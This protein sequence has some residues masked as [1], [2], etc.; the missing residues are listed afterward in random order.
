MLEKVRKPGRA[1]NILA[2]IIFGAICLTFVFISGIP[3][4]G[5]LTSGGPVALV[6]KEPI[7][8]TDYREALSRMQEQYKSQLDKLPA[9]MRQQ[10]LNQLRNN[11]LEML[12]NAQLISQAAKGLGIY[13][14]DE[15]VRDFIVDIPAFQ[16][17]EKFRRERY[18]NYLNYRRI[19]AE[20]FEEEIRKDV[21]NTQVRNLLEMSL[22][23]SKISE[24]INN[25]LEKY[26]LKVD[27]LRFP[28][29]RI[30][31]NIKVTSDEA[32][33]YTENSEHEEKLKQY[34]E[35]NKDKYQEEEQVRARH[36]LIKFDESKAGDKESAFKKIEDIKKRLETEDFEKLAGEMSEDPGSKTKGGDLGFFGRGKMVPEFEKV[37]FSA[38]LNKV[39]EPVKSQFGYHLIKVE[40]KKE[41]IKKTLEDVK[42][43]VAKELIKEDKFSSK[44]D[45]LNDWLKEGNDKS[46][47][48][49][50][51]GYNLNWQESGEFKLNARYLPSL[52]SLTE[53]NV[54]KVILSAK[55]K[56]DYVPEILVVNGQN[57]IIKIKNFN[58]QQKDK[59]K[60]ED[61][62]AMNSSF[63]K[64][65]IVR[66]VFSSWLESKKESSNIERNLSLIQ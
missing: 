35:N 30:K 44:K 9:A 29:S 66:D 4:G 28:D 8:F 19:S 37:A 14:S 27:F 52:S 1:K 10:Q 33:L 51:K 61:E 21:A 20:K 42:L 47:Q 11:A 18:D 62:F 25:E 2:Y 23:P 53:D 55:Q 26:S 56:K 41:A 12:I 13:S 59:D 36:I 7:S 40:E 24:E 49:W 16:E 65:Q 6:N 38:E 43:D 3:G 57:Y 39:S 31:E 54:N 63:R 17:E 48:K 15:E 45:Q 60:K 32:T 34:F 22:S 46:I 58:H 5:G 64:S 50:M